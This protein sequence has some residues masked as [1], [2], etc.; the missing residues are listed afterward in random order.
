MQ[1]PRI[2]GKRK[3]GSLFRIKDVIHVFFR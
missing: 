2:N 1:E 3:R